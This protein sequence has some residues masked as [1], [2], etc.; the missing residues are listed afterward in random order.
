ML[1]IWMKGIVGHRWGRLVLSGA[2]A[3]VATA[4]IGIIGIF[5]SSSAE[6]MTR[7][8]VSALPVDWQVA[9]KPGADAEALLSLLR[10]SAPVAAAE[11]VAYAPI[12]GFGAVAGGTTQ[13]TG[14][15]VV[16]GIGPDYADA[17]PGQVRLLSGKATGVLIAQQTASN[18]HVTVG[19]TVSVSRRDAAPAGVRIDGVVELP[20]GDAM[21]QTV[22]A[23]R[24][25]APTAP[26]DNVL[27]LPTET[28]TG[29]F[30][31]SP[32]ADATH[33]QI[34]A[35]LDR[36]HLPGDPDRAFVAAA[37]QAHGFE[38]KAAGGALVANNLAARLDAVRSDSL[39][40]RVLFLF[41][42][43]PGAVLAALLTIAVVASGA[44]RQR[45]EQALLRMRGAA[46]GQVL[47]AAALEAFAVAVVSGVGGTLIAVSL[48]AML[49]IDVF[50]AGAPWW[51]LAAGLGGAILAF[52]V[53]LAPAW[54]GLR[55]RT[56]A[57]GRS[58]LPP[59]STPLWKRAWL[60]V[61]LLALSAIVFWRTASTGYQV[62][63]APE[64]VA[65][66]AVDYPSFLAPL[67]LWVGC[68]LLSLRLYGAA[69][70]RGQR[71][72]AAVLRPF[73]PSLSGAVAAS[74]G[75]QH[76]RVASGI[77]LTTLA[78]SFAIATAIFNTTYDAQLNVDA[79]LTN[80]ADVT[81]TGT[82]D[83][84]AGERIGQI[85]RAP[86]VAAAEPMQH[87]FAYV[88]NDLQDL[89][90]IDP[91][92]I[93]RATAIADAYF[94]TRDA[95]A[96]LDHLARVPDGVLVA[97]ETVNDFQLSP[98]DLVNL[99]LQNATDRQFHTFPFHFVGVVA[100]FPTAPRDSFLVANAAYV[101]AQ[102]G[103]S[104]AEV[105]LAKTRGDPGR[106]AAAVT[107]ALGSGSALRVSSV[108]EAARLIGSS[109]TAVDLRALTAIELSFAIVLI[110]ASTGLMLALGFNE[111]RRTTTI[112]W[113]LGA[114]PRVAG[115]FLWTEALLMLVGGGLAGSLLG[116]AVAHM[117]VRLLT[118]VFD[119]PPDTVSVPW[120][121]IAILFATAAV[122]TGAAVIWALR[123]SSVK[124]DLG[125]ELLA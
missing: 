50:R 16:L 54:F 22:G 89:Y 98:G 5:A 28:W 6:N 114:S 69:L 99:R 42:G 66:T 73:S 29:L 86:G 124:S 117:L 47:R 52:V 7:R 23:S 110:A 40:A 11:I 48:A 63:L 82:A 59:P 41:L 21:F 53:A 125:S 94:A 34:H 97:Q 58:S 32:A 75:R 51:L 85:A 39:Y 9:V 19:D 118:G 88:G 64:G 119:P 115:T 24:A 17:F 27:L 8:A 46:A 2:G 4:L 112:L 12:D 123:R 37:A 36:S 61:V 62:V 55:A 38:L 113:A 56:I 121:Y 104:R 68:G 3:A 14:A 95:R 43:T 77:A 76:A 30:G 91:G 109:L 78:F 102:T 103:D 49:G 44:D 13:T 111:R 31:V 1:A 107:L 71:T 33:R 116:V 81:V 100:E 74:I 93:G 20:N 80:G 84:P 72:L 60:D 18:L 45:R 10:A 79:Q 67:F 65:G 120:L 25:Q 92:R 96:M 87:R 15:G 101:S 35:R 57:I 90:G 108:D 105:V 106:A 26:P 70:R 83:A 122:A